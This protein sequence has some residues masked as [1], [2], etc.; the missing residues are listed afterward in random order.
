MNP[1]GLSAGLLRQATYTTAR[2][3]I[4]AKIVDYLK[5][6]NKGAPLPLAQKAG[7]GLAAGGLGAMFGS[8]ADL[9]LIR[10]Q[11]DKTLP[12]NERRNYTGVV[13]ALSDIVKKEGVGGLFTGAGTT[14][15][16]AMALNMG[17]L[18]SND[19]AKEM[20]KET[21]ITGFPAT[22]T[23][24]IAGFFSPSATSRP[25]SRTEA[26]PD[27]R[28]RSRASRLRMKTMASGGPSSS[29]P[30]SPPTTSALPPCSR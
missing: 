10:M 16:R 27:A 26:L 9:S 18:A 4:H 11:A 12:V 17:M 24:A 30:V 6:A 7:A 22:S 13:H 19:Q 3:G 25:S 21:N 15:I 14:S 23:S 29:T 5:E 2:L 1:Q 20:L 28:C 8:P